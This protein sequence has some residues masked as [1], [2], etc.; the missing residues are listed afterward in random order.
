MNIY[1]KIFEHNAEHE[2][3]GDLLDCALIEGKSLLGFSELIFLAENKD[4][5][6]RQGSKIWKL[7]NSEIADLITPLPKKVKAD[8]GLSIT[9]HTAE[10]YRSAATKPVDTHY[11]FIPVLSECLLT[12]A[13]ESGCCE[14]AIGIVEENC[15]NT[16]PGLAAYFKQHQCEVF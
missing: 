6:C 5:L 11:V 1:Y 13:G 9:F 3:D 4:E 2:V 14:A 10:T 16:W 8:S 7:K 15:P 12:L